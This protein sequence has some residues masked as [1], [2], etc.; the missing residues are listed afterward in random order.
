MSSIKSKIH[1]FEHQQKHIIISNNDKNSNN[2]NVK[3]KNFTL[4]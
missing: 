3:K 1:F 2:I 4:E